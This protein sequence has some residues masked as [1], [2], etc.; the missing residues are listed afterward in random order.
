M[1]GEMNLAQRISAKRV[2]QGH[3][4]CWWL[5]GSGFVF[6]NSDGT[7]IYLDPYLSNAVKG[8]FGVERAFSAP[9]APEDVR[10]DAVISTHWH[11]DHLDPGSIPIIARNNPNAKFIMP[12]SATSHALSWGVCRSQVIGIQHGQTAQIRNAMIEAVPARHEAGIPGWD[13]PDAMGVLLQTELLTLYHSGDTEY[14]VRL[15]R[16]KARKPNVAMICINGISGNMDAYEAALLAWHLGAQVAIPI[17]HYLWA[18]TS[19]TDEETLDPDL[20]AS[21]YSRLGGAGKPVIPQ[22]GAEIDLSG[23]E[24]SGSPMG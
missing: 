5:G 16:L 2:A 19:G 20:F 23:N 17:H 11:E 13:V 1:Q 21:T 8:I 4:S 10:A 24:Y 22:I 9:V 7:V 14:D 3:V 6:K 18:T 12:P 15:R